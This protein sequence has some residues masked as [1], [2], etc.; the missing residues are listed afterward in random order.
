MGTWGVNQLLI[1]LCLS[2]KKSKYLALDEATIVNF[3]FFLVFF[4]FSLPQQQIM[5][6]AQFFSIKKNSHDTASTG[7]LSPGSD[8]STPV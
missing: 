6:I 4:I 8:W 7:N 3:I 2:N 1:A 5:L